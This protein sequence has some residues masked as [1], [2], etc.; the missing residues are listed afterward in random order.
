M[1]SHMNMHAMRP[2][3]Q[4][5]H[6][7]SKPHTHAH[8]SKYHHSDPCFKSGDGVADA[9]GAGLGPFS[10]AAYTL[11]SK[12]SLC[13]AMGTMATLTKRRAKRSERERKTR[14]G[15]E[16]KRETAWR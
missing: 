2:L 10:P 8:K 13:V 14:G 1:R 15:E 6:A 5:K 3:L 12:S 16:K 9:S 4:D 7:D 11:M